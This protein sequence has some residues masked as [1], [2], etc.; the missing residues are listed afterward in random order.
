MDGRT[1]RGADKP[2]IIVLCQHSLVG[3]YGRTDRRMDKPK[4]IELCQHSL[5]G[6]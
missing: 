5:A 1:D 2:K 3:P 6:P 4:T